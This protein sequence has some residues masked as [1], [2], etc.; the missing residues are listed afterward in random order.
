MGW[1]GVDLD[2]TLAH[3]DGWNG[4]GHIGEPVPAML[5]RVKRWVG[6]GHDVRIFTARVDGRQPAAV[7]AA[8]R[9]SIEDWCLKHIGKVLPITNVKDFTM[10]ELYDDRAI[11]VSPNTGELHGVSRRGLS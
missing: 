4:P 2:G 1:I 9:K 6:E 8:V 3:Y 7:V 11:H 5:E 10:D